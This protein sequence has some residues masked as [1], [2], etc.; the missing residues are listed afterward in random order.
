MVAGRLIWWHCG[1]CKIVNVGSVLVADGMI[2]RFKDE[3]KASIYTA[4]TKHLAL[5]PPSETSE[6]V[7]LIV[8]ETDATRNHHNTE[9]CRRALLQY[10]KSQE[11]RR[12]RRLTAVRSTMHPHYSISAP[13]LR[14][15]VRTHHTSPSSKPDP[16]TIDALV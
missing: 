3:Q 14:P 10:S 8:Q 4:G 2:L 6:T 9:P 15:A 12:E 1:N 11:Q 16:S 13:Q 5:S 7:K